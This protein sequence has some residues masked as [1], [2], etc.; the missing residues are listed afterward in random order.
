MSAP[1]YRNGRVHV[2]A[3]RCSTCIFAPGNRMML[4]NGRVRRMVDE[5][6]IGDSAIICHST[7]GGERA[8]CRGFF[9]VQKT[10]PIQLAER[11][12]L[13]VFVTPPELEHG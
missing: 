7:Y 10:T 8:I 3:E 4:E 11:L 13:L 1:P 6:K 9:D 12:G 5:A 2:C